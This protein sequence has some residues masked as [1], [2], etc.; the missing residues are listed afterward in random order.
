MTNI[1]TKIGKVELTNPILV[2]SGTFGYGEES[3]EFID[4]N[5]LGGIVTKSITVHPREG[6]PSPRIVETPSGMLN[7]IGLANIGVER[8]ISEMLPKYTDL[9]TAV[10]M[11]IAG[12][13]QEEYIDVMKRVEAVSNNLTGYEINI[14]C[15]NVGKDGMEFG[16]DCDL[17]FQLT[18]ELRQLTE[19]L[20]IIKLSPNVTDIAAIAQSA[21]AAGADAVSAINTVVGM[22]INPVTRKSNVYTKLCGLSGPAIKPVGVA[23]VYQISQSI[24]IP[25]IG[26]G[27]II[28][29]ED[30]VEY[31]LAGASA[32]QVGTANYRH[33]AAGL[34]IL[35]EFIDFCEKNNIS[36]LTELIADLQDDS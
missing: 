20:L 35:D 17:T 19:K 1:K 33:P 15:P 36:D 22:S 31:L 26:I 27:G 3:D 28:T 4:L 24:S 30:V 14:S 8:Y 5:Q 23:S 9:D 10:I 6:N 11:N 16:V 34:N 12:S 7:S 13:S 21:E 29:G 18:S 2:A 32:V 25:V